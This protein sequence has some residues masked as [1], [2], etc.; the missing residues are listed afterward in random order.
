MTKRKKHMGLAAAILLWFLFMGPGFAVTENPDRI[1]LEKRIDVVAKEYGIPSV[2]LKSIVRVESNYQHYKEDGSP[3]INYNRNGTHDIG[4]MQINSSSGYD[5]ERLKVDIDYNIHAGVEMIIRKWNTDYTPQIG[6]GDMTVLENWYFAIWA[7]NGWSWQNNPNSGLKWKAYQ[8][9]VYYYA[10]KEFGQAITP[11]QASLLPQEKVKIGPF[12]GV[13]EDDAYFE[14]PTPFHKDDQ[15]AFELVQKN[16]YVVGDL[17]MVVA[18]KPLNIRQ[19]PNGT[20]VSQASYG[21]RMIVDSAAVKQG[22]YTWYRVRDIS[23]LREGWLAGEYV[24]FLVKNGNIGDVIDT[25]EVYQESILQLVK[26]GAIESLDGYDPDEKITREEFAVMIAKWLKLDPVDELPEPYVD[27]SMINPEYYP[28]L[29][30]V[31]EVGMINGY[32]DHTFMPNRTITRQEASSVAMKYYTEYRGMSLAVKNR[33]LVLAG[34]ADQDRV[35]GWAKDSVVAAF[36]LK[37]LQ[38]SAIG[39][40]PLASL[41]KAEAAY[42]ISKMPVLNH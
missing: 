7:Y 12:Y 10:Q 4:L 2:I 42:M 38:E 27:R 25:D 5:N 1:E 9:L 3:N 17:V 15:I 19:S 24:R 30:A 41:T 8:D 11:I 33:D 26:A 34:F 22:G 39:I 35:D 29:N 6:N 21:E 37:M 31:V 32:P 16:P 40:R 28:Y 14:T 20:V 36:Q 23:G 18:G 13:P